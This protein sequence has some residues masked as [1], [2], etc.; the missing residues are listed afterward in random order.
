MKNKRM[1]TIIICMLFVTLLSG[2]YVF[3]NY[4][5]DEN[6]K[7]VSWFS[8]NIKT[9]TYD[10]LKIEE[11]KLTYMYDGN[12]YNGCSNYNY[13]S[14]SKKIILSCG[15]EIVI[16]DFK[17]NYLSL[18]INGETKTFFKATDD[19]LNYEFQKYYEKS[20][21]E[22]ESEKSQI[23]EVVKIDFNKL[24]DLYNSSEKNVVVFMGDE[25]NNLDCILILGVLEKWTVDN[26]NVYFI[27]STN[28]TQSDSNRLYMLSNSFNKDTSFYNYNYPLILVVGG[29]EIYSNQYFKC[30]G[31]DCT[32]WKD[33]SRNFKFIQ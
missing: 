30:N 11:S 1:I 15:K 4:P 29:K 9:G 25:C 28:L 24:F 18:I 27:D 22:Y 7:D 13:N 14:K 2:L 32:M 16:K 31:L 12:E 5:M 8:Y 3:Y 26:S 33:Y 23:K 20:I 10:I 6:I 21:A 19:A 17:N